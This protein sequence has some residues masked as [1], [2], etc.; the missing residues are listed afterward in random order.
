[1]VLRPAMMYGLLTKRQRWSNSLTF[2]S[3]NLKDIKIFTG[4]D[5]NGQ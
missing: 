4:T 5:Q 2:V 1:M 3:E